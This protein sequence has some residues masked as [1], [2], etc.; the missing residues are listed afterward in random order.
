[1]IV[2]DLGRQIVNLVIDRINGGKADIANE[3]RSKY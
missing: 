2:E 1:M 3:L